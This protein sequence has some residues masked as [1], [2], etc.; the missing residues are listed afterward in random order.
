MQ[1]LIYGAAVCAILGN[2]GLLSAAVVINEVV[3]DDG[4][5]DDR[6]Y[7]ELFNTGP[8]RRGYQ[9]LDRRRPGCN[10]TQYVDCNPAATMLNAGAFYVVGNTGVQNVNLVAAAGFLENDAETVELRNA[11][12]LVD[13]MLYESNK[14]TTSY[15]VLPGDVA[16]NVGPGVWGNNQST[17]LTGTPL[18]SSAGLARYVDGRDTNNNGRDWGFRPNTPGTSNNPVNVNQYIPPNVSAA[19]VGSDL[20][21]FG[22]SF[23]PPRVINPGVADANNPNAIPAPPVS[24]NRA[25]IAWDSSGGG[26]A[27]TSAE[28]FNSARS[29]F[30]LFAYFETGNFPQNSNAAGTLFRGSEITVYG[31][32]STEALNNLT[33]ISGQVGVADPSNGTTGVAWI[34]EKVAA[35]NPNDPPGPANLVSEK[36]YLVDAGDGGDSGQ[37]GTLPFDWTI[38]ATVDLSSTPSGWYR[39][40]IDINSAGAGVA[41]FN[42]QTFNFTTGLHSGAFGVAYRE[43]LQLRRRRHARCH[44]ASA[45]V[46]S[47]TRTSNM[48]AIS[49]GKYCLCVS[50]PPL[51]IS[52]I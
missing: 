35:P 17:D 22:Y 46:R 33:D 49:A 3:Y 39:L 6:E 44:H 36:L 43:N 27:V 13:A 16:T 1:R 50:A 24:P 8:G 31:I 38:L 41:R 37:G 2:S 40:G 20:P 45:D 29:K 18:V 14:G 9:R 7:V 52:D 48:G 32:G 10:R 28:T 34:Y 23:I 19:A 11:G 26:N 4:G 42:N 21:G 47:R 12:V 15:G 51:V 30:D 25:I 5:T